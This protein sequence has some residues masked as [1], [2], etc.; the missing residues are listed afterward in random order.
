MEKRFLLDRIHVHRTGQTVDEGEVR[1]STVLPH[2]TG[3][4][5]HVCD[6]ALLRA[7]LALDP[8]LLEL[9]VPRGFAGGQIVDGASGTPFRP[10]SPEHSGSEHSRRARRGQSHQSTAIDLHADTNFNLSGSSTPSPY[11]AAVARK[12]TGRPA[13][14]RVGKP[15]RRRS[16]SITCIAHRSAAT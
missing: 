16:A 4:A 2:S 14:S 3:P 12:R 9:A 15:R 6:R 1:A 7:E 11:R 8:S 5:L 10:G 13:S